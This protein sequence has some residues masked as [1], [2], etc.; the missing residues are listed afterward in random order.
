MSDGKGSVAFTR[1]QRIEVEA[2]LHEIAA[3]L[4]RA[5]SVV[6]SWSPWVTYPETFRVVLARHMS[7]ERIE[8][9]LARVLA[10]VG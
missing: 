6:P 9:E 7:A 3:E 8:T 5:E 10:I 2:R 1:A 4:A